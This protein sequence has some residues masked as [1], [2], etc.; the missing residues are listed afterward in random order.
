MGI[1]LVYDEITSAVV[2]QMMVLMPSLVITAPTMSI[3]RI[4]S[5][6]SSMGG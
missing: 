6:S 2:T 4:I 5:I 1:K 3:T